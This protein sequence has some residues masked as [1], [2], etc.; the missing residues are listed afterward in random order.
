MDKRRKTAR[1]SFHDI[2]EILQ[3]PILLYN[4]EEVKSKIENLSPLGIGLVVDK[5][6]EITIGDVFYLKHFPDNSD[7]KCVC[8]YC[9]DEGDSRSIGAYFTD[10]DDQKTIMEHLHWQNCDNG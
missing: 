10:P 8:V 3:K 1:L 4:Y 5:S 6:S 2:P 9:D 7:I